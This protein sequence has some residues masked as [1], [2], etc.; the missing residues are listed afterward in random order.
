MNVRR[1]DDG[2]FWMRL[3]DFVQYYQGVGILEIIPHATQNGLQISNCGPKE[4]KVFRMD[5]KNETNMMF[6]V[7][8]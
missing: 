3:E 7:D 8:Q 2:I 4:K 1:E 6:S 5:V